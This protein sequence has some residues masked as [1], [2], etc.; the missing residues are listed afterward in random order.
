MS[1]HVWQTLRKLKLLYM[2]ILGI[3]Q[4]YQIHIQNEAEFV[5]CSHNQL[6]KLKLVEVSMGYTLN[7]PNQ[8][9]E[10]MCAF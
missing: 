4:L 6:C 3:T 7:R 10:Y 1:T 5:S 2:L 9:I 8:G